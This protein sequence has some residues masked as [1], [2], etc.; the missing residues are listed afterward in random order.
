MLALDGLLGC[1][2]VDA[3]S[4]LVLAREAR[5]EPPFDLDLAAASAAQVLRAHRQ[6][7]RSM[8]LA[9]PV[10]EI[11]TSA[12]SR[13]QIV[14]SLAQHPELFLVAL[15]DKRQT[16]LALARFQLMEVERQLA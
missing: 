6:A 11:I 3:T 16:N 14:R 10:D 15:F 7:A 12:G 8:G 4:G 1:A 13:Q 9:E 2:A 5:D